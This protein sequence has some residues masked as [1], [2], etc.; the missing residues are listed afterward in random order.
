MSERTPALNELNPYLKGPHAPVDEEI[1]AHDLKVIGEIP[2]DF[3][4]AYY[5]N[6]PNPKKQPAGMHHWFDGDG[7]LHAA[8][9]EDGKASYCNRYIQS[10]DFLAD[11]AGTQ[12]KSGIFSPAVADGS[13][14]VYKDT[15]NTDV[16]M[17]GG[18]LMALWYIS[19][20]PVRLDAKTLETLR[21]D[22]FGG[23]CQIMFRLIQKSISRLASFCF[24]TMLSMTPGTVL[25]WSIEITI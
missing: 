4:G 15:A 16:I 12:Q 11:E 19:G 7:M 23:S 10:A 8:H 9:F 24:L 1:F 21:E 2:E 22:D 25:A 20:R 14:T 18:E 6:G 5:R 3:A 17:H 13:S